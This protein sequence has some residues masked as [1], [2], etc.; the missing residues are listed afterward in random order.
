MVDGYIITIIK[1][2]KIKTFNHY[3]DSIINEFLK[4]TKGK[5]VNYNPIVIEYEDKN[6]F[7]DPYLGYDKWEEKYDTNTQQGLI[8]ELVKVFNGKYHISHIENI[9]SIDDC[10]GAI[11]F[12]WWEN[13]F[14]KDNLIKTAIEIENDD[15]P[16]EEIKKEYL[17]LAKLILKA[18]K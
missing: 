12:D 18:L 10:D 2:M 8:Y 5:V 16:S 13:E 17:E 6:N 4:Q 7:I 15:Y 3:D 14:T 1:N 11:L 9:F